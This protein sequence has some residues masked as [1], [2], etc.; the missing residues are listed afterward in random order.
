MKG[1]VS[2]AS[3]SSARCSPGWIAVTAIKCLM[4]LPTSQMVILSGVGE[5]KNRGILR[6][7]QNDNKNLNQRSPSGN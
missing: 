1:R 7:A 5:M 6:Y 2:N 3:S 4:T